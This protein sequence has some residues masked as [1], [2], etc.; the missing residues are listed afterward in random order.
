MRDRD[1][2]QAKHAL[3]SPWRDAVCVRNQ[4]PSLETLGE[5]FLTLSF[6]KFK[7]GIILVLLCRAAEKITC[8]K[9]WIALST[10]TGT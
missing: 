10:V 9:M 3:P 2:K 5:A 8:S 4:A 1:C 6:L 7:I